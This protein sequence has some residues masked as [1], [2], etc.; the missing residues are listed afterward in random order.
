[1]SCTGLLSQ[2]LN[3]CNKKQNQFIYLYEEN[4]GLATKLQNSSIVAIVGYISYTDEE[5][6]KLIKRSN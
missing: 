1:M 2:L 6:T 5:T 3:N 4:Y